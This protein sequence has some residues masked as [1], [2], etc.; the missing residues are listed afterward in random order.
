M[1]SILFCQPI[2]AMAEELTGINFTVSR[3]L[4]NVGIVGATYQIIQRHVE[5]VGEGKLLSFKVDT[6]IIESSL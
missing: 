4:Q 2:S 3:A 6:Q 5:E 1:T